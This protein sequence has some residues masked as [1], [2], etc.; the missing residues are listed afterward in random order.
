VQLPARREHRKAL[1]IG[2]VPGDLGGGAQP[3]RPG[4]ECLIVAVMGGE[5]N[6]NARRLVSTPELGLPA[7]P[8]TAAS[9][10]SSGPGARSARPTLRPTMPSAMATR[11]SSTALRC[12]PISPVSQFICSGAS[13]A[14]SQRA[15]TS[16]TDSGSA[17]T[18]LKVIEMH[19][20]TWSLVI[21]LAP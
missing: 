4:S 12:R 18:A 21:R 19:A 13:R 14:E 20:A 8:Q 15:S 1:E 2:D 6:G 5:Q 9:A 7:L 11:R 17:P 16:R 3:V 10:T